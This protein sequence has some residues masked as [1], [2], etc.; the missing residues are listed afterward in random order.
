VSK[1]TFIDSVKV[2]NPCSE[3]WEE[4]TGNDRVRFCSHCAKDVNDL[5]TMTRKEA[6]RLVRRSDGK[7][8]IRYRV[9]PVTRR[10]IFAEQ[11]L[12][13]TR[14]APGLATGVLTASMAVSTS[15]YAQGGNSPVPNDA[16]RAVA[17]RSINERRMDELPLGT[18]T[19]TGKVTDPN[20]A[21]VPNAVV[22]LLKGETFVAAAST[23]N[24]GIYRIDDVEIGSY[25]IEADSPGFAASNT[26]LDVTTGTANANGS[27]NVDKGEVRAD[28][29]L[30]VQQIMGGVMIAVEYTSELSRAVADDDKETVRELLRKGEK[31]NAKEESYS[32]ITPIF[33]AVETGDLE[34]I[35]MLLD[36]GAKVNARSTSKETPL[37]RL[38][39]DATNDLVQLL[40]RYG[41]KV[42]V[43]DE[44]G[45]TPL[46]H[47]VEYSTPEAAQ[48]LIAAG[49]DVNAAN[50]DGETALMKA[51]DRGDIDTLRALIA[52]G[53]WINARDND[54]DNA[55]VYADRADIEELLISFGIEIT[56]EQR[57]KHDG[58]SP[59]DTLSID[60]DAT[61]TPAP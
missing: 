49:A 56:P 15:A 19:L 3:K 36:A 22:K 34:L 45:N 11:L 18:R 37:M 43:A 24:D 60:P 25:R 12:Q 46:I 28:I 59:D 53:A 10:P 13:I 38:D 50:S 39:Q 20:G 8:C 58:T 32:K 31:V 35:Q 40:L 9:D 7:I 23:N 21:A 5:S 33:L 1:R 52:A 2:G 6:T 47:A 48:A 30:E 17:T 42:N 44:N 4:M 57:A 61:P 16:T 51:A 54:G 26:G 41:A 27:S 29:Q 14:R 55:W